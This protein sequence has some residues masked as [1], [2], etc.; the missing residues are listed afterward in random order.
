MTIERHQIVVTRCSNYRHS[1]SNRSP[2]VNL[3]PRN[4]IKPLPPQ[5][6]GQ[7]AV[8]TR[9]QGRQRLLGRARDIR[10]RAC[11]SSD[12]WLA[13]QYEAAAELL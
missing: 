1:M 12:L 11:S 9:Q 6:R 8:Q 2:S 5:T 7:Q 10:R 3:Q 13:A 4:P